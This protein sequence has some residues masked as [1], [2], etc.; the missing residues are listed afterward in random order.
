VNDG[1]YKVHYDEPY[2]LDSFSESWGTTIDGH[3][4]KNFFLSSPSSDTPSGA[5]APFDRAGS[6][7]I[8]RLPDDLLIE[9]VSTFISDHYS[10]IGPSC[11]LSTVDALERAT[12]GLKN[13]YLETFS[14]A[15][16][17][18][19]VIPDVG[20]LFK[21]LLEIRRLD[22]RGVIHLGDFLADFWL[23][24]QFG[25]RPNLEAIQELNER[26]G[27]LVDG[28][29]RLFDEQVEVVSYGRFDYDLPV[30]WIPHASAA[31]LTARTKMV[32]RMADSSVI[33]AFVAADQAGVLP[34]ASRIW[35]VLPGSFAVDWIFAVG[36]RLKDI[37][38]GSLLLA[39]E[40][41]SLVH[42]YEIVA[43]IED[44]VLSDAGVKAYGMGS[45]PSYK[46][47]IRHLSLRTPD[48]GNSNLDFRHPQFKP[49][50]SILGSLIW[51]FLRHT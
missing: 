45:I 41:S 7:Y 46:A 2:G 39:T 3:Y 50:D 43:N 27:I 51:Q 9:H 12:G 10:D 38:Q 44:D 42:S 26:G 24:Y 4:G 28:F 6:P 32:F 16:E 47:F 30:S 33:E 40:I 15:K 31:H 8:T 23:Q 34:T 37:E 49:S 29:N 14:E 19:D 1:T 48:I 25:T 20:L 22:L 21:A 17:L 18:L 35:E 13:N 11:F 36:R 5:S